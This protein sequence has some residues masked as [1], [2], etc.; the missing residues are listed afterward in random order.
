MEEKIE[1][2]KVFWRLLIQEEQ[3]F[4]LAL[5]T[6]TAFAILVLIFYMIVFATVINI[7]SAIKA[8]IK[9]GYIE[10]EALI[11]AIFS[12]LSLLFYGIIF[13]FIFAFAFA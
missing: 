6:D 10:K 1:N 3:D 13:I 2:L 5:E 11:E 12:N 7:F 9:D 8:R 4:K